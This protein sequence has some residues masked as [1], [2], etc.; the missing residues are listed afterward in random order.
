MLRKKRHGGNSLVAQTVRRSDRFFPPLLGAKQWGP[1][2]PI[3]DRFAVGKTKTWMRAFGFDVRQNKNLLQ[4]KR[5]H[6]AETTMRSTSQIVEKF[7]L[8]DA[9]DDTVE[10]VV[11]RPALSNRQKTKVEITLFRHWESRRRVVTFVQCANVEMIVDTDILRDNLP[12]NTDFFYAT[13]D[14]EI[15]Q[16]LVRRHRQKWNVR[17]DP[18]VD[19]MH[20]KL[21]MLPKLILFKVRL[22]GGYLLVL[23]KSFTIK[24]IP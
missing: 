5:Q 10:D 6:N 23:A 17:Y 19:P 3:F 16:R 1:V 20:E 9:H 2:E 21:S 7:N 12:N 4:R 22:F 14:V 13:A 24:R 18:A 15:V 8:I 11:I